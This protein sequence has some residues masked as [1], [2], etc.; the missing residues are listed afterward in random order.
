MEN[1]SYSPLLPPLTD[2][3]PSIRLVEIEPGD[4]AAII[5][6]RLIDAHLEPDLKY[7]SLSYCWGQ[8]AI[9][10]TILLNGVVFEVTQN[11]HDALQRLRL[12]KSPRRLWIDDI[13]VN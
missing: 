2:G 7:E 4:E 3:T 12:L 11:L 8:D 13:C 5:S 6:A 10:K 1:F 9:K